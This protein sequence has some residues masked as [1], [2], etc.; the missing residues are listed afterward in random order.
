MKVTKL[1]IALAVL[2]VGAAHAPL[3]AA[4]A[5]YLL[6]DVHTLADVVEHTLGRAAL[7]VVPIVLL[8]ARER[9]LFLRT[10]T[11]DLRELW[12]V[13]LGFVMAM[14]GYVL[15]WP[16][17]Q[18]VSLP[19]CCHGLLRG[20]LEREAADRLAVPL[21]LLVTLLPLGGLRQW[22]ILPS[23]YACRVAA[24][25]GGALLVAANYPTTVE[26]T[27]V[28]TR[29]VSNQV[30]DSCSGFTIFGSLLHIGLAVGALWRV[31][32]PRILACYALLLPLAVIGNGSRV[33][34]VSAAYDH[35]GTTSILA[36]NG[37]SVV[38]AIVCFWL[39]IRLLRRYR[40]PSCD[41]LA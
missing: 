7:Y 11:T 1:H 5:E 3:Y 37:P 6:G 40:D 24:E 18:S 41:T 29:G 25:I 16:P 14:A 33:A 12:L 21:Y 19:L 31:P 15:D 34:S 32:L 23:H 22:E 13:G 8:M 10:T 26:G 36:H 4:L 20:V 28:F 9:A 30:L 17:L 27:I 39:M 2:F 35:Y 38:T